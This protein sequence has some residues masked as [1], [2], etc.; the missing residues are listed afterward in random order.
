METRRKS[1][2]SDPKRGDRP[3][4]G[5]RKDGKQQRFSLGADP[6][7][8]KL[9][10]DRIRQ[11][12]LESIAV[13]K[14]FGGEPSWTEAA[15]YAA[16]QIANGLQHIS[17]PSPDVINEAI[18]RNDL[19]I[20]QYNACWD[21]TSPQALIWSHAVAS[22]H[23]PSVHWVLPV[24]PVGQNALAFGQELYNVEARR[25]ARMLN[26][27]PPDKPV[28]GTFYQAL[29]KY[30]KY[31]EETLAEKLSP[32]SA[33]NRLRY[34]SYFK[35]RHEDFPLLSLDFNKCDELISFW[36]NRPTLTKN[37][38][39]DDESPAR[40]IHKT[41]RQI[42][43]ELERFFDWL[44]F[45]GGF[46]WSK[47]RHFDNIDRTVT[48]DPVKRSIKHLIS[49]PTF[50]LEE[51]AKINVECDVLQRMLLYLGLNCAFGASEV[52][53]IEF[54]DLYL[55]QPN[56]LEHCWHNQNY[57]ADPNESWIA[58]LRPKT[59]VAGCWWL[60]PETV[61][62]L[63]AWLKVRPK[64]DVQRIVVSEAGT[65]LYRDQS[66]N[67]QSG[68]GNHWRSF[69][70]RVIQKYP[71]LKDGKAF[72]HLPFGT[73][74]DQLPDWA[75]ANGESES[76][77]IALAHGCPFKDDLL[78]CYSNRPFPRMFEVQRQY[79]EFLMPVFDAVKEKK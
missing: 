56:P 79:R 68:F 75:V 47:P 43:A 59:G 2:K 5:Y 64:T 33:F 39:S 18:Q 46:G 78:T 26:A 52:G 1:R 77:S 21:P 14:S 6:L 3:Y 55:R 7:Q 54:D 17:V 50:S 76:G 45:R 30:T 71:R 4:I 74:R 73:L 38:G 51:L 48:K 35:M 9:R 62:A 31:L 65:S 57:K 66:K 13:R 22:R 19:E 61:D 25:Q 20:G 58:F 72:Q 49:K 11:L 28:H 12:Y 69:M 36:R 67:A 29:D 42:L 41:A 53:R 63:E 27:T 16:K 44:D 70:K 23:Y 15:L 32:G 8:A 24:G 40:Y 10:E 37:V 34:V 60:F